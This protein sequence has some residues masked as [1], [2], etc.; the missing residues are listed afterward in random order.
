MHGIVAV[1]KNLSRLA[2]SLEVEG[3][4]VINLDD[5]DLDTVDAILVSGADNNL[6]NIQDITAT[7]PVINASGKTA[8]EILEELDK[9]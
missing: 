7:V 5:A 3:Y 1:E 9:L 8:D 4:E 6:M 2:E